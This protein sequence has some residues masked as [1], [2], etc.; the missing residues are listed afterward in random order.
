L[1]GQ[2]R[3]TSKVGA[4][5]DLATVT[6][7]RKGVVRADNID[8]VCMR[9]TMRWAGMCDWGLDMGIAFMSLWGRWVLRAINHEGKSAGLAEMI[10]R[11][12][13]QYC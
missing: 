12:Y 5:A 1:E 6:T 11:S 7:A 9:V 2:W 8:L 10:A 4:E 3:G 13:T